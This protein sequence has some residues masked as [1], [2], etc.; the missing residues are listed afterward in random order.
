VLSTIYG[1]HTS[2]QAWSHLANCF[3]LKSKSRISHLKRQLQTLHQGSKSCSD[4]LLTAKNWADQLVVA[5]KPVDD[6][7]LN[8]Y[9]VGGLNSSCHSFITSLSFA[10]RDAMISFHDFQYELLNFEHLLDAHHKTVP[11][12]TTQVSFFTQKSQA[13]QHYKKN[14]F[15][16]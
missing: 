12:E 8:S 7:D 15:V 6:E 13:P 14:K 9:I 11:P 5:S 1:L 16:P 4:Y 2:C 10:T 3:A